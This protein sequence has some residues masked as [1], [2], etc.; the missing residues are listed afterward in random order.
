MVDSNG[1]PYSIHGVTPHVHDPSD[2]IWNTY[3]ET[4]VV[5]IV[6]SYGLWRDI[7]EKVS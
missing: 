2:G 1:V 3:M 4:Y 6:N 7:K 5:C